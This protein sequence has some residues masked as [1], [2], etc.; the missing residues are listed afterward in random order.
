MAYQSGQLDQRV[1]FK[2]RSKRPDGY[3]GNTVTVSEVATVWAYVRPLNGTEREQAQRQEGIASYM[4]VI[5]NRDDL[6]DTDTAV[7]RGRE[8]NLRFR[9]DQGPRPQWLEIEADK[10][11]PLG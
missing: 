10:G 1:T 8:F 2:R 6:L 11:V 3:G 5:R 7:W 9:R 4:I